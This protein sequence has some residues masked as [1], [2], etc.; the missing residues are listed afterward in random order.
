[1][2]SNVY[3]NKKVLITGNTGFKGSWLT[4]WLRSLGADIIGVSKDIPTSPSLFEV[5]QLN[6]YISF[7]DKDI[8]NLDDVIELISSLN[9]ISFFILQHR[10]LFHLHMKIQLIQLLLM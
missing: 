3:K 1:M 8:R 9:Q 5:T 6:D 2:F 7:F 4:F 10:Q